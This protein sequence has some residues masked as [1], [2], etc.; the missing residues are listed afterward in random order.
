MMTAFTIFAVLGLLEIVHHHYLT[1]LEIHMSTTNT[2]ETRHTLTRHLESESF[3]IGRPRYVHPECI[4]ID[5]QS[6]AEA[7]CEHC[8]R[9][10]L[11]FLPFRRAD[12]QRG[13]RCIAWC[14]Y[15]D[16]AIEF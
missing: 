9:H 12:G 15:C 2:S 7:D 13:Y 3:Q 14:S 16:T 5:R 6:A 10:G 1:A 11:E 4:A 8:E